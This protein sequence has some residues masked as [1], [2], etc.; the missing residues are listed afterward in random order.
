MFDKEAKQNRRRLFTSLAGA[1]LVT[2][3]IAAAA[4]LGA[5]GLAS[6]TAKQQAASAETAMRRA[7][8]QCYAIEGRYPEGLAYL[9]ENYGLA[10]DDERFVYHYK[11]FAGNI[12]PEMRVFIREP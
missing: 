3:A 7:A 9:T 11:V 6:A 12:L 1:A 8:A 4:F 10:A 2:G 5:D